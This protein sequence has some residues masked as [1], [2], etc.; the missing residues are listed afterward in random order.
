MNIYQLFKKEGEYRVIFYFPGSKTNGIYPRLVTSY[1]LKSNGIP[2]DGNL[3]LE[4]IDTVN[5]KLTGGTGING[6]LTLTESYLEFKPV[7]W[8][9]LISDDFHVINVPFKDITD[10]KRDTILKIAEVIVIT[11]INGEFKIQVLG[12]INMKFFNKT[13]DKLYNLI[14]SSV[15]QSKQL[16]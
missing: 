13:T 5:K 16:V 1:A 2:V 9:S 11:T 4:L 6:T 10:V 8:A 12:D 7:I 14:S 15:S 3:V